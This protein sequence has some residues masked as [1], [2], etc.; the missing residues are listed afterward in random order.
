MME[1]CLALQRWLTAGLQAAGMKVHDVPPG[2]ALPPYVT[3]GPDSTTEWSWKGGGGTEHR[4]VVTLWSGREGMQR[5]KAMLS[6]VEEVIGSLPRMIDGIRIVTLR[7]LRGQVK[8]N[9]KSWTAGRLELLV[10]TIKET[11]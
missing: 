10:R 7:V 1:E 11:M 9:P 2:D 3:L 6:D 4:L 5:T 8:R